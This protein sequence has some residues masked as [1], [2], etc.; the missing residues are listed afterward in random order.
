M[1]SWPRCSSNRTPCSEFGKPLETH[2]SMFRRA[3]YRG[4]RQKF[5]INVKTAVTMRWSASDNSWT[6]WLERPRHG[7]GN[8]GAIPPYALVRGLTVGKKWQ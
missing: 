6:R 4:G 3:Y 5:W 7:A 1:K 2:A 8:A